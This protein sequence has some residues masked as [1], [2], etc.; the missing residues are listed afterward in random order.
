TGLLTTYVP[1]TLFIEGDGIA[2]SFKESMADSQ[3]VRA[4]GL[5]G[6][7]FQVIASAALFTS[8]SYL[9]NKRVNVK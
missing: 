1:I 5:T 8:T 2:I 7:F 6:F 3:S 9:M 4:L